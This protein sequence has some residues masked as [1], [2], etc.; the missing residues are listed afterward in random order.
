MGSRE[1]D[2]G[3][4]SHEGEDDLEEE[5]RDGRRRVYQEMK[6]RCNLLPDGL[7][8]SLML[9]GNAA[10]LRCGSLGAEKSTCP[11][12]FQFVTLNCEVGCSV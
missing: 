8:D 3:A 2:E 7:V 1:G 9:L 11:G 4:I 5:H 10:G 12:A 6:S